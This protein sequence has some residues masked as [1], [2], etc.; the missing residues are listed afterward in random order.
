MAVDSKH[1]CGDLHQYPATFHHLK[2]PWQTPTHKHQMETTMK[3]SNLD[4]KK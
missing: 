3:A 4:I 2:I 1:G